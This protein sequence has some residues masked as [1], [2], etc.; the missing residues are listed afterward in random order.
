MH[1]LLVHAVLI[2]QAVLDSGK[3]VGLLLNTEKSDCIFMSHHQNKGQHRG[4]DYLG[5]QQ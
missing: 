3:E 5:D 1:Q 2:Y 4:G